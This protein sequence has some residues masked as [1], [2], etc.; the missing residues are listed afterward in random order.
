MGCIVTFLALDW[1]ASTVFF[2]CILKTSPREDAQSHWLQLF[3][4]SPVWVF[5]RIWLLC[6]M[7][8]QMHP[9]ITCPRRCIIALA[10]FF[11]LF[12]AVT[13]NGLHV[14]WNSLNCCIC[15]I[16]PNCVFR[17]NHVTGYICLFLSSV[18]LE[19]R[20]QIACLGGWK[21]TVVA[22]C[23]AFLHCVSSNAPSNYMQKR[24]QSYIGY[25][26]LIFHQCV[27]KCVS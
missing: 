2:K 25:I 1:L 14:K 24:M 12:S 5:K 11:W 27:F 21:V 19:M 18:C 13:S 15:T 10:A 6:I 16:F 4:F 22:F 20:P 23:L 26:C 9:Q 8:F 7:C 17:R 3:G